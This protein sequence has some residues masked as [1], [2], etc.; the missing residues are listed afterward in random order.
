MVV[1]LQRRLQRVLGASLEGVD[2]QTQAARQDVGDGV[3]QPVSS[4][5]G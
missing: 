3:P 4:G 2:A 5:R 1:Q